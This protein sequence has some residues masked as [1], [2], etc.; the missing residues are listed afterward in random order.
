MRAGTVDLGITNYVKGT[1]FRM[2]LFDLRRRVQHSLIKDKYLVRTV[3]D[4]IT[5]EVT[6]RYIDHR[7]EGKEA[8]SDLRLF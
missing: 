1:Y 6:E 2:C 8:G 5:S 7:P 4:E 3:R